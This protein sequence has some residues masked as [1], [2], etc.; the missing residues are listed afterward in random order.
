M[1]FPGMWKGVC[2]AFAVLAF[3]GLMFMKVFRKIMPGL[4][5]EGEEIRPEEM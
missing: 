2:L 4:E 3:I 1:I 5:D